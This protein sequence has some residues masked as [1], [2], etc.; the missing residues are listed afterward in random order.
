M[1]LISTASSLIA[2]PAL[3][4]LA[5]NICAT[6]NNA[7]AQPRA[8]RPTARARRGVGPSALPQPVSIPVHVVIAIGACSSAIVIAR[9]IAHFL[10]DRIFRQGGGRVRRGH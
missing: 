10:T 7:I 3:Q 8:P 2:F 4:A 5:A 6:A 1:A 9:T